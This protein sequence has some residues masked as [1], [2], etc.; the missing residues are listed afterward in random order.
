[1]YK[2][3]APLS[4]SE[5][6]GQVANRVFGAVRP[7]LEIPAFLYELSFGIH[8]LSD[9]GGI[10]MLEI[11]VREACLIF[12]AIVNLVVHSNEQ[13]TIPEGHGHEEVVRSTITG[14]ISML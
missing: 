9:L 4:S 7:R 5:I 12:G 10:R 11:K 13:R 2:T 8:P 6:T 1:M 14:K 3:E